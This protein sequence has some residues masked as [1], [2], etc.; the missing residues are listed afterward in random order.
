MNL[1]RQSYWR[2]QL[3]RYARGQASAAE[4]AVLDR[5]FERQAA[6]PADDIWAELGEPPEQVRERIRVVL[7]RRRAPPPVARK[8]PSLLKL[9]ASILLLLGAA[10]WL[11]MRQLAPGPSLARAAS[12]EIRVAKGQRTRL[13]LPDGTRIL[14]NSDSRLR[15]QPAAYNRRLRVVYLEGEAFFKVHHDA[16]RP[17][18]V[19]TPHLTT[20]VLGTSFN[21]TTH[22]QLDA[23]VVATGRVQVR[24]TGGPQPQQLVLRA[25]QQA[26]LASGHLGPA[27][28]ATATDYAWVNGVLVFDNLPLR[29]VAARLGR[30]YNVPVEC[31]PTLAAQRLRARYEHESL[32]HVVRSLA[33]SLGTTCTQTPDGAWH[34]LL[35]SRPR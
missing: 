23:V 11:W 1:N 4:Q 3:A 26:T 12:R 27:H 28:P 32:E 6:G 31:A 17:F 35:P 13:V 7:R 9:A 25:G 10:G 14:L 15:W 5:F 21:V 34:L 22:D 33:F 18:C 20:R 24:A 2:R 16:Q 29:Q 8:W 30:W 19:V